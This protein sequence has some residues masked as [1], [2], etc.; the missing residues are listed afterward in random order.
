[1]FN[2]TP[3]SDLFSRNRVNV[4]IPKTVSKPIVSYMIYYH[5]K[6]L[7]SLMLIKSCLLHLYLSPDTLRI[8]QYHQLYGS[9]I[10]IWFCVWNSQKKSCF[11]SRKSLLTQMALL[12]LI[13]DFFMDS[14]YPWLPSS[15]PAIPSP[16]SACFPPSTSSHSL[17]SSQSFAATAAKPRSSSGVARRRRRSKIS[18]SSGGTKHL[19]MEGKMRCKWGAHHETCGF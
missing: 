14:C 13:H 3:L 12:W 19:E 8:L 2:T 11:S 10:T 7:I 4:L 18:G 5:L 17:C 15:D 16:R 6:S 1:M 9:N